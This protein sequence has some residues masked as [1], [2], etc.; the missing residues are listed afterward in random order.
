MPKALDSIDDATQAFPPDLV[1]L[2]GDTI[3][4]ASGLMVA[5]RMYAGCGADPDLCEMSEAISFRRDDL[6]AALDAWVAVPETPAG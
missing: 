5:N 1:E 4:A 3:E 2:S 6:L